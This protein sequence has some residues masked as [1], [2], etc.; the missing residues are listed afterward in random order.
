[1]IVNSSKGR[2]NDVLKELLRTLNKDPYGT[3]IPSVEELK[4]YRDEIDDILNDWIY[5]LEE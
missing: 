5:L 2:L 4:Y 1:M 3:F